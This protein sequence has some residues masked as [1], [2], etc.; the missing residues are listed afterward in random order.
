MRVQRDEEFIKSLEEHVGEAVRLIEEKVNSFF[1]SS[2]EEKIM[3]VKSILMR[4]GE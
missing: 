4:K 3:V 2:D 1:G